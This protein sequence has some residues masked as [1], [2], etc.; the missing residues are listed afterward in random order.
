MYDMVTADILVASDSSLSHVPALLRSSSSHCHQ[1]VVH[2]DSDD[3][4]RMVHLG[5][6][7]VA[8]DARRVCVEPPSGRRSGGCRK[9]VKSASEF[10]SRLVSTA[11][12]NEPER[13]T[14]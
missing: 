14:R 7:M 4:S 3:R 12:V 6:F 9:W 11:M 10:W 2:P 5:W 13:F 8:R 1:P